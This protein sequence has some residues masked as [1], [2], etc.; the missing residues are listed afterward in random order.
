MITNA[1]FKSK[2]LIFK[3]EN[4]LQGLKYHC[5]QFAESIV[6]AWLFYHRKSKQPVTGAHI[7]LENHSS[8]RIDKCK[9]QIL[10]KCIIS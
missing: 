5:S 4:T 3:P 1:V 6:S 8:M 2:I 9:L 10:F 7:A